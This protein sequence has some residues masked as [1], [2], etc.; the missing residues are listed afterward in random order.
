MKLL[1]TPSILRKLQDYPTFF[2]SSWHYTLIF[3]LSSHSRV[4]NSWRSFLP[5]L[6]DSPVTAKLSLL[7]DQ[8]E[9]LSSPSRKRD[10]HRRSFLPLWNTPATG[11]SD[12]TLL[13]L[14]LLKLRDF[15]LLTVFCSCSDLLFLL[16]LLLLL[17]VSLVLHFFC[18]CQFNVTWSLTV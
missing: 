18:I 16:S 13:I 9:Q 2:L 7:R 14:F 5:P 4:S 6:L 10:G 15:V 8:T 12:C 1:D 17:F 11:K 3:L